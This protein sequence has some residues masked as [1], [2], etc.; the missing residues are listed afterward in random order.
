[1]IVSGSQQALDLVGRA[2]IDPG[3]R[4]L[5][6]CPT[7]LG[8]L[9]AFK[10]SKPVVEPLPTDAKGLNPC[11]MT[12]SCRG[13]RFAY[14]MPTFQNPTGLTLDHDRRLKLAEKAREYDLWLIEDNPY[15]ELYYG[16]APCASIRQYAPERTLT[17]GTMSKILAPGLRLGYIVAPAHVIKTL[18]DLKI[19]MDLHTSTYSQL[20]AAR[21]LS[22]GILKEHLPKVRQIYANKA[23]VMLDSLDKFM[24]KHEEVTWTRP[25]GGMFIWLNLPKHID[26]TDL[27][28]RVLASDVPVGFV[29]GVHFYGAGAETNHARFSFVTVP[30]EKIVRGIESIAKV[31]KEMLAE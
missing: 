26:A 29:P 17:L 15:S 6:E 22:E 24:P 4:I 27:V 30:E 10:M 18:L 12:E 11:E 8:A 23:K 21:L 25:D 14:V 5:V 7:Y 9:D 20:V 13:A 16:E 31:L 19:S 3:S 2:F 28:R 1:M